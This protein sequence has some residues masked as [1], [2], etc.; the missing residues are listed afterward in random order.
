MKSEYTPIESQVKPYKG[1][2]A[3]WI[4]GKPENAL[5]YALTESPGGRFSWEELPRWNIKNFAAQGFKLFYLDLWFDDMWPSEEEF[6]VELA[7]KQVRGVLEVCPDAAVF[8]RL[9]GNAPRWWIA[10]HPDQWVRFADTETLEL[11]Y[12]SAITNPVS[13]DLDPHARISLASES[14]LEMM[15]GMFQRFCREFSKTPE[16]ARVAAIQI[17]NGVCG[18]NHYWAFVKHDPDVSPPMQQFFRRWLTEKY[19]TDQALQTAWNNPGVTLETAEVPGMERNQT[20]A[21]IF[22]DPK[23]ERQ[24]IDYYECQSKAVTNSILHFA[25]IVK[26]NWPRDI[27]VGTF[28]G[29]YLS[30]FGRHSSGG[31]LLEQEILNCPYID[32]LSAPQAYIKACRA[33]GGPTLSRGLIESVNLHGKLWLDEMDQPTHVG[34]GM[35]GVVCHPK[36]ISMEIIKRNTMV[37]AVRGAGMWYFDYGKSNACGWWDDPDYMQL[38]GRLKQLS[39]RTFH[40]PYQSAAEVLLVFDTRVFFYT[41][42]RSSKDPITDAISVNLAA[43][44]AYKTGAGVAMA[45]LSDLGNIDLTP[46]K[47]VVFHNCFVLT[48][49][50]RALIQHKVARDGRHLIWY[51]FPGFSDGDC[52][53]PDFVGQTVGI[54]TSPFTAPLLPEIKI[55]AGGYPETVLGGP[56]AA[57]Q[58]AV[59][60]TSNDRAQMV[61]APQTFFSIEDSQATILGRY[62]ESGKAAAGCKQ[63]KDCTNW[64]FGLPITS[65]GLLRS[66]FAACGVHI[67]NPENDALLAG[68]GL[69]L[70]H[71]EQ[72]G[73]KTLTLKNGK[74]VSLQLA[75]AQTV[76]LDAETGESLI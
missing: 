13:H 24:I 56:E 6:S 46:Y 18:E 70:L 3:L 41:A 59:N 30:L 29:Y 61:E 54:R 68:G 62:T 65:A 16:S 34:S 66:L 67:Y 23:Q 47:A 42:S 51:T 49:E 74:R 64:F 17:A 33:I 39:D 28:Y 44:E 1:K 37:S 4:N 57:V 36:D 10:S 48:P 27:V 9:H 25:K 40:K 12:K 45:Y 32:Y 43:T 52:I 5:L 8:F 22:H 14:W 35:G 19:Q 11:P 55:D 31:H 76:I 73:G 2:P 75:P 69:I 71:T 50:Q 7:Q 20:Q 53:N 72:G 26:E 60:L 38:I 15:G 21:G 58:A 63:T